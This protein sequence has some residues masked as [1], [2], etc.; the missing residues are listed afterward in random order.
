MKKTILIILFASISF[1]SIFAQ[2]NIENKKTAKNTIFLELLGNSIWYSLNYD[3]I[4]FSEKSFKISGRIGASYMPPS[5]HFMAHEYDFKTFSYPLQVCFI[6][7]KKHHIEIGTGYT[8]I[9]DEY[10]DDIFKIYNTPNKYTI[11]LGYRYQIQ[12]GGIFVK[13][14]ILKFFPVKKSEIP[15]WLGFGLGYTF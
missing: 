3:R 9:F 4:V 7:G 11:S 5:I 1:I 13:V 8:F 6:Y 10:K 15:F 14:N 2:E 12:E